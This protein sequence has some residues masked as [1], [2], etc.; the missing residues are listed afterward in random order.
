MIKQKDGNIPNLPDV[1]N[2]AG[3]IFNS[4]DKNRSNNAN[5]FPEVETLV[6][7]KVIS[8]NPENI[9][10]G[11]STRRTPLPSP[12]SIHS[13][14]STSNQI[15]QTKSNE[16]NNSASSISSINS[17]KSTQNE[18]RPFSNLELEQLLRLQS[19]M[20]GS[21][22]SYQSDEEAPE[23]PR[24]ELLE[25]PVP[26]PSDGNICI[27]K[28]HELDKCNVFVRYIDVNSTKE[29][30][31]I[32]DFVDQ[33]GKKCL[34]MRSKPQIGQVVV[35]YILGTYARATVLEEVSQGF[36]LLFIDDGSED[37]NTLDEMRQCPIEFR[38]L[39]RYVFALKLHDVISTVDINVRNT[40]NEYIESQ[41][42]FE[43]K[44]KYNNTFELISHTSRFN[45]NQHIRD[46]TGQ[47][48]M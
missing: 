29:L 34:K 47:E 18:N 8:S 9:N 2:D 38:H 30:H 24:R 35:G 12:K 22:K 41:H 27:L 1:P 25:G 3:H 37:I 48:L 14:K 5:I 4:N 7:G 31:K 16:L 39:K 45:L 15:Q 46:V 40:V 32:C 43:I 21:N 17:N 26:L 42:Q 20:D 44:L 36:R 28:G 13:I 10:K 33:Y 23:I 11:S 19:M 6:G